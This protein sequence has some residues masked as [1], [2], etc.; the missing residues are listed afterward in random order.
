M[1]WNADPSSIV[2]DCNVSPNGNGL[3]VDFQSGGGLIC[4]G[5][6]SNQAGP[7]AGAPTGLKFESTGP[8]YIIGAS[9]QEYTGTAAILNGAQNIYW[10]GFD[11][12]NG[13]A[14]TMQITNCANI[15]LSGMNQNYYGGN[16]SSPISVSNS[17]VSLWAV[18]DNAAGTFNGMVGENGSYYGGSNGPLAGYID[19]STNPTP[20]LAP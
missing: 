3:A 14:P 18:S 16:L 15:W 10:A 13:P 7:N 19:A 17:Q 2:M 8:L 20:T 12:E 1:V 11:G 9:I 5:I 6:W 4:G